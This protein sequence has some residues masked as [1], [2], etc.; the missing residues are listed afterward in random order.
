MKISA[1]PELTASEMENVR[2]GVAAPAPRRPLLRL[3]VAIL[4]L[5]FRPTAAEF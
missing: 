2:G 4:R 5:I 1:F 3:I